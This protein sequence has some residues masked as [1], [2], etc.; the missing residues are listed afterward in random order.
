MVSKSVQPVHAPPLLQGKTAWTAHHYSRALMPSLFYH[1]A[2]VLIILL[3]FN[4]WSYFSRCEASPDI[5]WSMLA[6]SWCITGIAYGLIHFQ[7]DWLPQDLDSKRPIVWCSVLMI[8][9]H[10]L[11]ISNLAIQYS[12]SIGKGKGFISAGYAC[13][14]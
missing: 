11:M 8:L 3:A 1:P 4:I 2:I 6:F 9:V 7:E 13:R 14:S 12:D 10:A 5:D